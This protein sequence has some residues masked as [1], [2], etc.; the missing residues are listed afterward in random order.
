MDL[1]AA[2]NDFYA[3]IELRPLSEQRIGSAWQRLHA[4][5]TS[6]YGLTDS[7]VFIQGSYAND[8][9]VRPCDSD[10]EYDVDI[11]VVAIGP[12]MSAAEAINDLRAR[13][14]AD[15]DLT[16]RLETDKDGRPCVRL[17]YADD[18]DE[19]FGFHIDVVPSRALTVFPPQQI[20][21]PVEPAP[22]EV[23][24]RGREQWRGTAPLHYTRW[25]QGAGEAVRR[26]VRQLKRWREVH[27]AQV[28]SIVLQVLIAANH[29]GPGYSD[30][31]TI[32]HTLT[33]IL[34]QLGGLRSAPEIANPALPSENLADRW[35]DRDFAQFLGQLHEAADLAQR[36]RASQDEEESHK[37]WQKLLGG[38]F[39]DAPARRRGLVVPPAPTTRP[40]KPRPDKGRQYG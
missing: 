3:A 12:G 15:G 22:L 26:T 21:W 30:A 29:P 14:E 34:Q 31:Y 25:C 37:L 35:P 27:D 23:P 38:D 32:E 4:F 19:G 28:K 11:V 6:T 18:P 24:M 13:L 8:T 5:L 20:V 40:A 1:D 2:F 33:S 9:A 7:H 17:R 16:K 39:P 36:A 10:G